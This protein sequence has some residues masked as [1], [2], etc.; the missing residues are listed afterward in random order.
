MAKPFN[1]TI[2]IYHI[3][4]QLVPFIKPYRLM[5]Y[6]TLFLTFLGALMAQVNPLVLKYTVDEVTELTKQTDPM[7]EGIH[8]LV[9]ISAILLGKELLNIFIQFGQKFYGEKIR[10]NTSS[11]LAQSVIDKILLYR[12][13]Y[14]NDENHESGKL[15]IRIDR[16]IESLTKLVQ[17]FFIDILPLFST[18]IIA[19]IVMYMQNLY[20]GLVSTFV[21]PIY[22][23]VTSRQ[24]KK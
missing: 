13:A 20:V 19:L 5:I 16:G 7:Q 9:V 6:G 15:Q 14:F 1:R 3:Y 22:F 10:I 12:V 18:A 8:V 2:T 23:Y 24:A 4:Q 21:I 17:N 11:V